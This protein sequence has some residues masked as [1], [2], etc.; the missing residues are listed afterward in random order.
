MERNKRQCNLFERLDMF[1][2]VF[3][4]ALSSTPKCLGK[5]LFAL[6]TSLNKRALCTEQPWRI[7]GKK[8]C[9]IENILQRNLELFTSLPL[10]AII[11]C[12]ISN[13]K[14]GAF[15]MR[16]LQNNVPRKCLRF[17]TAQEFLFYFSISLV[18]YN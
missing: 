18:S 13:A 2:S 1:T 14:N 16:L 5:K 7:L 8:F 10:R 11:L 17:I 6:F 4:A 12:E 3:K 9:R 15:D